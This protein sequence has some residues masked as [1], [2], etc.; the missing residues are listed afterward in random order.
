MEVKVG[1]R[2][3]MGVVKGLPACRFRAS[4]LP[5]LRVPADSA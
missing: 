2:G 1:Y 5:R 3:L 4:D